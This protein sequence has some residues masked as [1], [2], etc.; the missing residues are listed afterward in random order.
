MALQSGLS[1][2]EFWNM[3]MI[4]ISDHIE[5]FKTRKEYTEKLEAERLFVL[6]EAISTRVAFF[7]SSKE[8]RR[9]ESVLMPWDAYPHFFQESHE[10]YLQDKQMQDLSV[11]RK[12][13]LARNRK[14]TDNGDTT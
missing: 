3:S 13:M 11:R 9:E 10:Q 7:L 2:D 5:A 14:V 12:N 6:A 1:A 8:D 4:E